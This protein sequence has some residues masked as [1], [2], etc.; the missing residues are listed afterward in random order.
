[1]GSGRQLAPGDRVAG[2]LIESLAGKGGMGWVYRARQTRPERIVALKVIAP[3]LAGDSCFRDRFSTES[4]IAARI[5]HPNV[6]PVYEVGEE[7]DLLFIVMRFVEGV[8]LG[9]LRRLHGS[10]EPV[11]AAALVRQV[12]SALDA[13][14]AHGLVHRDVKPGN[15]L[16]NGE[17]PRESAYLTDFGLTK[18]VGDTGFTAPGKLVGSIDYIAP[19]QLSSGHA[20]ARSDV[21]GLGCVLYELLTGSVPFPRETPVAKIFAHV[22]QS[23]P[24]PSELVGGLPPELDAVVARAMAKDPDERY[25]SAGELAHAFAA[26]VGPQ[27]LGDSVISVERLVASRAD[28][29][30]VV[31]DP[32]G[33]PAPLSNLPTFVS[34]FV[35]RERELSALRGLLASR[36]LVTL[37]GPGGVGK[38]RLAL[39]IAAESRGNFDDGVWLV[40]LAPLTSP[41]LVPSALTAVLRVRDEA[42]Q[43]AIQRLVDNLRDRELLLVLDNCE[44]L[45]EA[46]SAAAEPILRSCPRVR[47][48]ATSREALRLEGEQIYRVPPLSMS[49]QH[50]CRVTST[51]RPQALRRSSCSSSAPPRSTRRS[52]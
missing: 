27:P 2:F 43:P 9:R 41:D 33:E 38:T 7:E 32:L 47:I 49:L 15:V 44:H 19:E 21:Y 50:A 17:Y 12:G 3:E 48:L 30:Q 31:R 14:H 26:S 20:D 18:L 39:Q 10:L 29:A 25:Q 24:P 23:A 51:G 5:E 37:T 40:D 42:T 36:R 8:D 13:A 16:V 28:V 52:R 45:L 35:G 22:N 1:M 6:I 4:A 46:I 11:H 34:S